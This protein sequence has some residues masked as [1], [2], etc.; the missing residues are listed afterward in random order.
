MRD[1]YLAIDVGTGGL[2]S[3]LVN[4]DGKIVS[5]SHK[6][7][8][9]IVQRYGWS[10]QRPKD[11]WDGTLATIKQVLS[12]VE[13]AH[14]RIA[15]ICC[16]GQMHGTVLI[17]DDGR[18]VRETA[19]LWNDKRN[20][21]QVEKVNKKITQE[22]SLRLTG[23][24][25]SPAWPAQKLAW[26]AENDSEIFLRTSTV[27]MPKDWIN[28]QLTGKRAQDITEASLSFLMDWKTK[29]WSQELCDVTGVPRNILPPLLHPEEILGELKSEV[30]AEIGLSKNLPVLVGA[31]DYPMALIG[32]GVLHTGM[33]SDV[34]GTST[35]ITMLQDKP[36]L[37]P[38]VSNVL[39]ANGMWGAMTLLDSGGDA[40]RWA[41]RAFHNNEVGYDDVT[42]A[43]ASAQ[44]GARGLFFLPYLTGERF[45]EYR[46]S[47]A[48]FFGLNAEHSGPELHRAVLEGVAFSMRHALDAIKGEGSQ[49]PDLIVAASG[50]AK[51]R[52]WLEIKASMYDVPFLVPEEL[53]CGVIGAAMLM[54]SSTGAADNIE[55]A[56]SKMVKFKEEI[57]PNPKWVET[58][59][60]MMPIYDELYKHSQQFYNKLDKVL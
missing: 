35:I 22:H 41:R 42:K 10:E 51:N 47:R 30:A 17:D 59:N 15:A 34:T 5:F 28:F 14:A 11:W 54:A 26:L 49:R 60:R 27:L 2:R 58:Y 13:N 53:E 8:E 7:H 20:T 48:Q 44:A 1:L 33:G 39:S 21:D 43:A 55:A 50:G 52:T 18:L 31:G 23:N 37:Q 57:K 3:A 4:Q 6:E 46:N 19:L 40:Q 36:I 24:I 9:Q 12:Q 32:S 45:G 38:Q 25:P 56:A 16:C 29:K